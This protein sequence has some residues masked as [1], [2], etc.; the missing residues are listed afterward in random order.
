MANT[1][2]NT[3]ELI[4]DM[5]LA[6]EDSREQSHILLKNVLDKYDYLPV[7]DKSFIKRVLTGT[8]EYRIKLDYIIDCFSKTPVKK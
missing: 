1:S 7:S 6:L 8:L 2:V 5:L 3:R 4:M